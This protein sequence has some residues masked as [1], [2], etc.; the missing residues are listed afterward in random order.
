M[1]RPEHSPFG[2]TLRREKGDSNVAPGEETPGENHWWE[3]KERV[4][5]GGARLGDLDASGGAGGPDL[6][7][8]DR[9]AAA[10]DLPPQRLHRRV[11]R[12]RRH[13]PAG[14]SGDAG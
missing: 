13:R 7:G 3:D 5:G 2:N 11:L 14:D 6:P 10:G 8:S 4:A 9:S 12:P 1:E